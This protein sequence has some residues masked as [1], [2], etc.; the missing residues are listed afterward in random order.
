[1]AVGVLVGVAVAVSVGV[2]VGI[3]VGVSVGVGVGV[4][5]AV[6]V[7]VGV[8]VG[9]AVSVSVAVGRSVGGAR[10]SVTEYVKSSA[11]GTGARSCALMRTCAR[12]ASS[13][14]ES[15]VTR[16]PFKP[17]LP[18]ALHGVAV[19]SSHGLRVT[20]TAVSVFPCSTSTVIELP[21]T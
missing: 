5:V 17:R 13:V 15:L 9:L 18:P 21:S 12:P 1:V 11:R 16:K 8:S 10:R 20:G 19:E 3:S 2:G 14:C 7:T 4:P 6:G